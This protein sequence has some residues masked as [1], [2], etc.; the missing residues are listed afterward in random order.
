ME[1]KCHLPYNL[2]K[3]EY[4]WKDLLR[5]GW[6]K[7]GLFWMKVLMSGNLHLKTLI[8]IRRADNGTQRNENDA[9]LIPLR[10]KYYILPVSMKLRAENVH[11]TLS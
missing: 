4:S 6:E 1:G 9:F 2:G 3:H 10:S 5:Y 11:R 8:S 7:N